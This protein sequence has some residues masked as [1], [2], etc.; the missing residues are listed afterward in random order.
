MPCMAQKAALLC[1]AQK[2]QVFHLN[3]YKKERRDAHHCPHFPP[4]LLHAWRR[5]LAQLGVGA[6]G[7]A[8]VLGLPPVEGAN[9]DADQSH[10]QEDK[11]PA[12]PA[13]QGY[14]ACVLGGEV[15]E[16]AVTKPDGESFCRK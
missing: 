15:F 7:V 6:W 10:R 8:R 4:N 3:D 16:Q 5:T 12:F 2:G 14:A 13:Q 11:P 1:S 9:A